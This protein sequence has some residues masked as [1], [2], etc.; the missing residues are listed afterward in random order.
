[1]VL[2]RTAAVCIAA[3][4]AGL[5]LYL[6]PRP[7]G[8]ARPLPV[9]LVPARE[10]SLPELEAD[11]RTSAAARAV[12]LRPR[13]PDHWAALGDVLAG[14][15]R[16]G[17]APRDQSSAVWAYRQALSFDPRCAAAMAGMAWVS[18]QSHQFE[19]SLDWARGALEVDPESDFAWGVRGDA[20]LEMGEYE[21]A[22]KSY[23]KMADLRPGLGSYARM[24]KFLHLNGA[25]SRATLLMLKAIEAGSGLPS[26]IAWCRS[27]LGLMYWR[28]GAYL[29]AAQV[30]TVGLKQRPQSRQLLAALGRVKASLGQHEEAVGLY[31]RALAAGSGPETAALLGDLL[32]AMGRREEGERE[33]ARAEKLLREHIP[34]GPHGAIAAARF[35][36]EHDRD[37]PAALT[38]AEEAYSKYPTVY[39]AD[40]LA[41][42]RFKNHRF[43][44]ALVAADMA[45]QR[46]TP[47]AAFHFH[48]AIILARLGQAPAARAALQRAL[49]LNPEFCPRDAPLARRDLAVLGT[50][51]SRP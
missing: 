31:R 20:E 49:S 41:W 40:G 33:L 27:E 34:T 37:L 17:G 44:D 51:R 43:E 39:A 12:R 22:G 30:L 47:E 7:G 35:L 15:A 26:D 50:A 14:L 28:Q 45:V 8:R 16:E 23:R 29:P 13:D 46:H 11:K 1:M 10:V 38:L 24:A 18:G 5:A 6:A 9:P 42:S 21:A 48:R 19:L 25:S 36:A 32:L 3:A 2:R 4:A